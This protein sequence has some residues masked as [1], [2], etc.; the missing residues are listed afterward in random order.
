MFCRHCIHVEAI[1]QD[2]AECKGN[3]LCLEESYVMEQMADW[4]SKT[5]EDPLTLS[6][7]VIRK[8]LA[9][10]SCSVTGHLRLLTTPVRYPRLSKVSGFH[11]HI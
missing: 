1:K 8:V 3:T 9:N 7:Q 2:M 5:G 11:N 6:R 10:S 4:Q